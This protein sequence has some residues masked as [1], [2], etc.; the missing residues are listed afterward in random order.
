MVPPVTAVSNGFSLTSD[1]PQASSL[2][3]ENDRAMSMIGSPFLLDM[4]IGSH[5]TSDLDSMMI[6]FFAPLE[7]TNLLSGSTL[8]KCMQKKN[9]SVCLS[10]AESDEVI[11]RFDDIVP[12]QAE[13]SDIGLRTFLSANT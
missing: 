12:H 13:F 10:V 4:V 7:S 5:A 2:N 11:D 3:E 9:M 1:F 8:D 6:D